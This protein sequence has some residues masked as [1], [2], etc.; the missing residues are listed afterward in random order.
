MRAIRLLNSF[1]VRLLLLLA[2]LLIA[3]LG[4]QFYLNL[5]AEQRVARTIAEQ[6]QAL[7]AGISL[8]AQTFPSTERLKDL[9][10]ERGFLLREKHAGRITNV[11]I[12]KDEGRIPDR[13]DDEDIID[14][15]LDPR[16]IPQR[17]EDGTD[18]FFT[19]S[20]A[21]LPRLVNA[22]QLGDARPIAGEPRAFTI[23][24]ATSQGLNYIIVVLGS[25]QMSDSGSIGKLPARCCRRLPCF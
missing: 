1:R 3:T 2:A 13:L 11:L 25:T 14:D 17:L 6:E 15:S 9:D 18:Q 20:E 23:S 16:L 10:T 22:E 8:A 12:V 24:A 7:A 5:R 21:Q 4:V 19:V